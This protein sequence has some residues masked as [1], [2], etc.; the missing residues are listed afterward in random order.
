MLTLLGTVAQKRCHLARERATVPNTVDTRILLML[1]Q[2]SLFMFFFLIGA[3]LSDAVCSRAVAQIDS[4]LKDRF[5]REAPQQWEI[6]LNFAKQLQLTV[7][8]TRYTLT[9]GVRSPV[10]HLRAEY[11][12]APNAAL[13]M[14]QILGTDAASEAECANSAY[15]F[16]VKRADENRGWVLIDLKT[17]D[18]SEAPHKRQE[19]V[20]R[21]VCNYFTVWNLWL[22]TLIRDP[23]FK[24]KAIRPIRYEGAECVL[25]DFEYP[26]AQKDYPVKGGVLI[27]GGQMVLD[28]ER[29]WILRDYTVH[30]GNPNE[31]SYN[32]S[33]N[34]RDGNWRHPIVIG[35]NTHITIKEDKTTEVF[36]KSECQVEEQSNMPE[37]EFT[38]SAF[39]L[40]EP[41]GVKPLPP[42]RTWLWLLAATVVTAA[43]AFLFA[44]LKRRHVRKTSMTF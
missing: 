21:D 16:V 28:P 44:W 14:H 42:S 34:I 24:I 35:I 3:L 26:K 17:F 6:Y 12:Q 18:I 5:L 32:R 13:S 30:P 27:K 7:N 1:L 29:N 40:P 9:N 4:D 19:E 25:I 10:Q 15:S 8:T 37:N 38:L 20:L 41:M 39:G 11:K 33:F 36:S 2:K 43:L 31:V 23:D 22:P